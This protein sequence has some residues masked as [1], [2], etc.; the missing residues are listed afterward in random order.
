MIETFRDQWFETGRER[1]RKFVH[2]KWFA[3]YLL[4]IHHV[5]LSTADRF[6]AEK[7]MLQYWKLY[8]PRLTRELKDSI[9]A[10]SPR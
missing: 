9:L 3:E 2:W 10:F 7:V 4:A 6:R 8:N 1:K 5:P